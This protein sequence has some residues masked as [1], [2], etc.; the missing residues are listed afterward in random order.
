MKSN[1]DASSSG[2]A[3]AAHD[4]QNTPPH[5]R[6]CCLQRAVSNEW[7][8]GKRVAYMTPLEHRKSDTAEEV[9]A[10]SGLCVGL[11]EGGQLNTC[12]GT[13]NKSYGLTFQRRLGSNTAKCSFARVG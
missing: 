10:S 6:Q 11:L 12:D 2:V 3:L 5:F 9:V 7:I 4:P 1:L 8:S 13:G